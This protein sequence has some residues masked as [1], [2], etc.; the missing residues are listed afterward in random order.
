VK[1]GR[2]A[3]RVGTFVHRERRQ[4]PW[5]MNLLFL[6]CCYMAL[7]RVPVDLLLTPIGR[8]QEVWFGIVLHGYWAKLTEPLHW[9]IY[10]A[11]AWGFFKMRYWMWPWAALYVTQIA[12]GTVVWNLTDPRGAGAVGYGVGALVLIPAALLWR[13][14][15]CFK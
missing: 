11:G 6:L 1:R 3:A 4:R 9:V 5:W 15:A 10:A 14:R 2:L 7:V 12:V 13:S 8:D